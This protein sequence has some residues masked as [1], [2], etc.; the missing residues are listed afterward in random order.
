MLKPEVAKAR[1]AEWLASENDTDRFLSRVQQLPDKLKNIGLLL[2]GRDA[3][4]QELGYHLSDTNKEWSLKQMT[5]H[6]H[7]SA[8]EMDQLL[9][10]FF[11]HLKEPVKV[12]W[13][14]LPN[15]TYQSGHATKAFRSPKNLEASRT[16]RFEWLKDIIQLAARFKDDVL[17]PVWLATWT[18]YTEGSYHRRDKEIGRL[19][20]GVIDAK[21][22]DADEVLSILLDCARNEH[23]IGSMGRHVSTALLC[24]SNPQGWEMMEKMLLAA[25]RQEG[26]R[27]HILE[28]ID[29][30]HPEAFRRMLRVIADQNLVRFSAVTRALDVWLGFFWDSISAKVVNATI[31][32]LIKLLEN[33]SERGKAL[34]GKNPEDAYL[35]L[36]TYAYE[37]ADQA[38]ELATKLLSHKSDE[39]R[40]AVVNLL[41]QLGIPAVRQGIDQAL[42]DKRLEVAWFA[43]HGRPGEDDFTEENDHPAHSTTRFSAMERLFARVPEKPKSFKPMIW[44]WPA[45]MMERSI[46]AE[47]MLDECSELQPERII[48]YLDALDGWRHSRALHS[49]AKQKHW[50]DATRACLIRAVGN[51]SSNAREA[52]F[53][54]LANTTL[55]YEEV[56]SFEKY[57][58]RKSSD[59]RRGIFKLVLK[60]SDQQAVSCADRLVA[61]KDA[62]QRL[63]G[64][65]L[66]R[67]LSVANRARSHCQEQATAYRA[68]RK[69]LSAQ[70][71]TQLQAIAKADTEQL[72]LSNGLGLFDPD[73]RTP[74]RQ[75]ERRAATFFTPNCLALLTSLDAL[76]HEHRDKSFRND[77]GSE[78]L[79][80]VV[81]YSFPRVDHQAS[82][83]KNI[84]SLPFAEIWQEWYQNRPASER[85]KDGLEIYRASL[86][87]EHINED[88]YWSDWKELID[89]SKAPEFQSLTNLV[90][91]K[92][93]PVELKYSHAVGLLLDWLLYLNPVSQT[94]S[95]LLDCLEAVVSLIPPS[96]HEAL[97]KEDED[98]DDDDNRYYSYDDDSDE[99]TPWRS[100]KPVYLWM[101]LLEG[102]ADQMALAEKQRAWQLLHWIDEPIEGAQRKRPELKFLMAALEGG[103]A[104][105]ND[106]YD[107]LIGK[108][109]EGVS[110]YSS[111]YFASLESLTRPGS[112]RQDEPLFQQRPELLD[113][114]DACRQRILEIELERGDAATPATLA[115]FKLQSVYGTDVLLKLIKALGKNAFKL[116]SYGVN[117]ARTQ[118]LTHLVSICHP[119][120]DETSNDFAAQVKAATAAGDLS[121]ERLLQLIF[122]APQWARLVESYLGWKG[123]IEGMCWYLAHM[124]YVWGRT[125]SAAEAAGFSE[126]SVDSQED[127]DDTSNK[128]SGWNK[129]IQERTPLT[130]EERRDGAIDIAWFKSTYATL[131]SVS[132]EALGAA[133]R[134][135]ANTQQARR[136]EFVGKVLL[137][138]ASRKELIDGVDKKKL[139]EYVRLLGL[140][141]LAKGAKREADLH[142]RYKV[143]NEYH[144]YAKGLSALS[145]EG[146]IRSAEIGI[147]NLA[148]TAG[149][150]DPLR[151]QWTLEAETVKD[152]AKGSVSA[153]K[154]DVKV[155]LSLDERAMPVISVEKAGKTLK[156]VPPAIKKDKKIAELTTR[157]TDL[158]KQSTRIKQSLETAMIRGDTFRGEELAQLA[159]HALLAPQLS[160]LILIGEGIMG[161]LDKKGKAL[162]DH[163]GKLEPVKKTELFRIAHPYDL[164]QS[165]AWQDWQ[166]DCFAAERIQPFKQ[167]FRELYLLTKQEKSDSPLSRRYAGQQVQERQALALWG[168]RNWST[169]DGVSKTFYEESITVSVDFNH[170]ITTPLEV[171]GLTLDTVSFRKRD[172]HKPMALKDVPPRIFSETMRDIDL[173]V[174]VAHRGGVDPEASASTVEMRSALLKET[175]QFLQLKNVKFKPSHVI[176]KGHWAEYSIHLGSG[177]VHKL[178]GGH[179]CIVPV[180][181]QHR[182]RLFLPFADDDPRTA[183]VVSKTLLLA[184]DQEILDPGILDQ[185]R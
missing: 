85:D 130:D 66:Y 39:F 72:S 167:V 153:S 101:E 62:L 28:A 41:R 138:E 179:L 99:V 51:T 47:F 184:R 57:L 155:T 45:V 135:A 119:R 46:V 84:A 80:G 147:A 25:Q 175:C 174:S 22:K 65:E 173:V 16:K 108:R 74:V 20:A 93:K 96:L 166:H 109:G 32:K 170:G 44:P 125:E 150:A 42:D 112:S 117:K 161:Y 165:K 152:L 18:P 21:L 77:S 31:E 48:P 100:V 126:E 120:A 19:L 139:K 94:G 50:S 154:G 23:E 75:P 90:I 171:E 87:L 61:S 115:A 9:G 143:L 177:T 118:T 3:E 172:T 68:S 183:E 69:K 76:I 140:L 26:L 38:A 157:V 58:T 151:M 67:H 70:E 105:L 2:L 10:T 142:E 37:D 54:A 129:F 144:R 4:G 141:P 158:K 88:Y 11:T 148:R 131:G 73:K 106:W 71:E 185:L 162:R 159:D 164:Y 91:G 160:R 59:Q 29:E 53:S 55:T 89:D 169:R 7:L 56:Q 6:D 134:Y 149:Y 98:S 64:L 137:G 60:Q 121:E 63:A 127:D 43:L 110:E 95:Y 113:A 17:T 122:L 111:D 14:T 27:Q 181:S 114:V 79:L 34:Q 104:N 52:A 36:W 92:N 40:F 163:R 12:T 132:W 97:V 178:P 5:A 180:H 83:E 146:A 13:L 1:I 168:S 182:G 8:K 107:E 136:A 35:A 176:I 124:S 123:L 156:T 102:N 86:W 30:S 133:A 81:D 116:V 128:T 145:K 24:S 82:R 49:L 103:Q 15:D 78:M 33:P